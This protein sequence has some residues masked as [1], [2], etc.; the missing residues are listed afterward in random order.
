MVIGMEEVNGCR[1]SESGRPSGMYLYHAKWLHR[2]AGG[3]HEQLRTLA[4][5]ATAYGMFVAYRW[6][7]VSVELVYL[8]VLLTIL[9]FSAVALAWAYVARRAALLR[10]NH[11]A[12]SRAHY[13]QMSSLSGYPYSIVAKRWR[14]ARGVL[15]VILMV[16]YVAAGGW[17]IALAAFVFAVTLY[18]IVALE[19]VR[20]AAERAVMQYS[21]KDLVEYGRC[22]DG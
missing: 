16:E 12:P 18:G 11:T 20:V 21:L 6:G 22:V 17:Y 7:W 13:R 3:R 8:A 4:I 19:S 9:Y 2:G 15:V 10:D 14:A 5:P 1:R